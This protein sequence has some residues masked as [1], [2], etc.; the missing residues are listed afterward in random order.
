MP[1]LL[2]ISD[3]YEMDENEDASVLATDDI[4]WDMDTIYDNIRYECW[5]ST[6]QSPRLV[7]LDRWGARRHF[8]SF[9]NSRLRRAVERVLIAAAVY[10]LILL[11]ERY[12][13]TRYNRFLESIKRIGM[14]SKSTW[15][16]HPFNTVSPDLECATPLEGVVSRRES[17]AHFLTISRKKIYKTTYYFPFRF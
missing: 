9:L 15:Q 8:S 5:P 7:V 1:E 10:C 12:C 11:V 16:M 4:S 14:A 3:G 6:L 17:R 13:V 2:Y